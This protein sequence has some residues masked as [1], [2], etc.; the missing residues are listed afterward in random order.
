MFR[1]SCLRRCETAPKATVLLQEHAEEMAPVLKV[2]LSQE[3]GAFP[4]RPRI[5]FTRVH[6]DTVP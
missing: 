6:A 3:V 4:P 1:A 2:A 5:S